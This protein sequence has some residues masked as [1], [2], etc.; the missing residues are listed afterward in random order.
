MLMKNFLY[1]KFVWPH[2]NKLNSLDFLTN[3]QVHEKIKS[4]HIQF[5]LTCEVRAFFNK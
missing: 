2:K 5:Q 4:L 3:T 1:K